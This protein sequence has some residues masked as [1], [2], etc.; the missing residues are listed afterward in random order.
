MA[1]NN[2]LFRFIKSVERVFFSLSTINLFTTHCFF[3]L[4]VNCFELLRWTETYAAQKCRTVFL[5]PSFSSRHLILSWKTDL[6]TWFIY[7]K[8]HP[9][10]T[11][12]SDI[13]TNNTNHYSYFEITGIVLPTDSDF[14][15]SFLVFSAQLFFL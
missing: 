1:N 5:L 14:W 11:P 13:H 4:S 3:F 10:S 8:L 2:F 6:M 9:S 7:K 15:I 12:W